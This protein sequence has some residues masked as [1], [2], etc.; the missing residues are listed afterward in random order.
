VVLSAATT[1]KNNAA[2]AV[3]GS[4]WPGRIV[5]HNP[6]VQR[7]LA[8]LDR[9]YRDEPGEQAAIRG[10]VLARTLRH[11]AATPYGRDLGLSD[12]TDLSSWPILG[13]DD[14]KVDET[15]FHTAHRLPTATA[16]TGGT[17]G[18]PL[19]LRRS[20]FSL[21]AEQFFLDRVLAPFGVSFAAS[22]IAVLRGDDVK[23]PGDQEPPFG[24]HDQGGR[25]L[26]LSSAHLQPASVGWY[27]EELRRFAPDFFWVYPSSVSS[28]VRLI[29]Q[30]G[31]E[32]RVPLVV[33]SSENLFPAE[34]EAVTSVLG[35]PVVDYYGQAERVALAAGRGDGYRFDPLYGTVELEPLE[36]DDAPEDGLAAATIIG[37]GHWNAAM[38]LVRY[39]TGDAIWYRPAGEGDP[40]AQLSRIAIGDEPF[41]GIKGRTSDFVLG[42]DGGILVGMNQ[43][44]RGLVG[45]VRMQVRQPSLTEIDILVVTATGEELSPED[46]ATLDASIGRK[47]PPSM[48]VTVQVVD[49]LPRTA[50]GK[51]PFVVRAPELDG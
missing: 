36:A 18:L 40:S 19:R 35:C 5:R 34:A 42:P 23:E 38:P 39:A 43:L 27:V 30:A 46:R 45:A 31:L 1:W 29:V 6:A 15:R 16:A 50:A 11:A 2:T 25:R 32:L 41:V 33:T 47:L 26:V 4:R 17:T 22:R 21:N 14:L 37:T 8:R 28:L 48:T 13:K 10:R 44:P 49:D 9:R 51:T 12:P 20:L 3:K 24:R 7:P